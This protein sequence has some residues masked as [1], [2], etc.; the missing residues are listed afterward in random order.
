MLIKTVIKQ[1]FKFEIL[2]YNS[3]IAHVLIFSMA[4]ILDL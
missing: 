2:N 3:K 4:I 1:F